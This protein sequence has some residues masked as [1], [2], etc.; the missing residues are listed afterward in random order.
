MN[1]AQIK[2]IFRQPLPLIL[3]KVKTVFLENIEGVYWGNKYTK[4]EFRRSVDKTKF[5]EN[6][7]NIDK[8]DVSSIDKVLAEYLTEMYL[9]HRFDLLG[10]GWVKNGYKTDSVGLEGVKFDNELS[11]INIDED[12]S[13]LNRIVSTCHVPLS[14]EIW[15][16]IVRSNQKYEPIDWQKD[17][18]VGFR[19]DAKQPFNK[20][21]QL[22]GA[23]GIDLKV[24][25]ELSRCQ[26]LP[27]LALFAK[28]LPERKREIIIEFKNQIQDFMMVNP[29]GMG[30]NWNCTMDV[31]IRAANIALAFDWFLQ[32]DD[33]GILDDYFKSAVTNYLY[34]HGKHIINNFE[35]KEGL[36]SN[37]YLGNI[38]GLTFVSTYLSGTK[39]LDEWLM[40]SIQELSNE[41]PKQF[42]DDGGNF[43]GSTAY[44]R[45]SGEMF[46]YCTALVNKLSK[47]RKEYLK[48]VGSVKGLKKPHLS[49]QYN[50]FNFDKGVFNVA[51]YQL[52]IKTCQLTLAYRKHEGFITQ[53]GDNDSG[54]FI[55]L[56]PCGEFL[57]LDGAFKKYQNLSKNSDYNDDKYWD[58]N[59]INHDT[60]LSGLSGFV[61]SPELTN[62]SRKY[63]AEY[64]FISQLAPNKINLEPKIFNPINKKIPVLSFTKQKEFN[65]ENSVKSLI[66]NIACKYFP[67]F[68]MAVFRS[69]S[70][71]LNITFGNNKKSHLSC[72]HQ[73]ND[74]LSV[75]I[76][77]DGKDVVFDPGTYIY[78][79]LPSKRNLFRS[80]KS[81][82][83]I[84]I[85]EE[86]N[87]F[88]P[89]RKGLFYLNKETE[90][91]VL[92]LTTTEIILSATYRDVHHIRQIQI[93]ANRVI[94]KDSCNKEFTQNFNSN[95][96]S[97]GYGKLINS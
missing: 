70:L 95:L 75:E 55:R 11:A 39:E 81:H 54:R 87:Q 9:S 24:P 28:V 51:Y 74:K 19:F 52:L 82:N 76:N 49:K 91:E 64:S 56:S 21:R 4:N 20:Q 97:N 46:V 15:S 71:Y 80:T 57:S 94:I 59:N 45:L 61:Q 62:Y 92:K 44:H 73:H 48:N 25:W 36:T 63:S 84:Y 7:V 27:Q 5:N 69:D 6:H 68:G 89:S 83:S 22:I 90:V 65:T 77:I 30:V 66:E 67:E 35:Y 93:E 8:I 78:S 34:W 12:G 41:L 40:L 13:W 96:F 32:I 72:G 14:K 16:K 86:Q 47:S 18:K 37:H 88:N 42:F 53:I 43:E 79:P 17:Y 26:H 50:T 31:G 1:I 85:G 10:T 3:S 33:D 2:I 38:A 58:E 23:E 60:Y 29:P